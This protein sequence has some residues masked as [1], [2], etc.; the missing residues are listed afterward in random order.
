MNQI[1]T[2]RNLNALMNGEKSILNMD[3]D[4]FLTP[5][6]MMDKGIWSCYSCGY[7]NC[8]ESNR[9]EGCNDEKF[10]LTEKNKSLTSKKERELYRHFVPNEFNM[11]DNAT[12]RKVENIVT[13]RVY[14]SIRQAAKHEGYNYGTLRLFLCGTI[15][16]K[17]DLRYKITP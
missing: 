1:L 14:R 2:I 16:N 11:A 7:L 10:V 12:C 17:T 13:G 9:C 4:G 6:W 5:D 15:V 3:T 8:I